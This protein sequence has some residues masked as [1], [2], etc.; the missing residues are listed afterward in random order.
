[1]CCKAFSKNPKATGCSF[2]RCIPLVLPEACK[3]FALGCVQG[4][5]RQR[6]RSWAHI[7]RYLAVCPVHNLACSVLDKL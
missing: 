5:D 6:H 3:R 4:R 1:M 2:V 7:A